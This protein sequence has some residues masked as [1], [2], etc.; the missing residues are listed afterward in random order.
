MTCDVCGVDVELP[1]AIGEDGDE[2]PLLC[3]ECVGKDVCECSHV[4]SD[5]ESVMGSECHRCPC[6]SFLDDTPR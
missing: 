6:P 2:V 4:R 5:H 3:E 1:I